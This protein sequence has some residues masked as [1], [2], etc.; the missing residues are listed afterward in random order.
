LTNYKSLPETKRHDIA[1]AISQCLLY[2]YRNL[3]DVKDCNPSPPVTATDSTPSTSSAHQTPPAAPRH[4]H[5]HHKTS[6]AEVRGKMERTLNQLGISYPD[7]LRG[8]QRSAARLFKVFEREPQNPYLLA[9]PTALDEYN[10]QGTNMTDEATLE[11]R[12]TPLL[13]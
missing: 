5:K 10:Q 2:Y 8:E 11:A 9:F 13:T 12:L 4:K 1:D 7:L 3:Q 6:K